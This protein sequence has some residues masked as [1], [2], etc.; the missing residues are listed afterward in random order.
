MAGWIVQEGVSGRRGSGRA[1]AAAEVTTPR[2]AT[3]CDR[4]RGN[5]ISACPMTGF[6]N[7]AIRRFREAAVPVSSFDDLLRAQANRLTRRLDEADGAGLAATQVGFMRRLF[8]FRASLDAPIEVLVNPIV[9][10]ASSDHTVFLEGCLSY[11]SVVVTVSAQSPFEWRRKLS[12]GSR[13]SSRSKAMRQN[14]LQH[15]IDH[16]DGILTIDRAEP[17]ER[18]RAIGALVEGTRLAV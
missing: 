2:R 18:R 10:A 12:E 15:E 13:G 8:A 14:L 5:T 9:S 7:G 17:A 1:T 16:L 6:G 4:L 11:Q 3:R